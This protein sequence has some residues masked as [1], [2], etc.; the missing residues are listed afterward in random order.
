MYVSCAVS[1]FH[2]YTFVLHAC[3]CIFKNMCVVLFR[4][5]NIFKLKLICKISLLINDLFLS[6]IGVLSE[7]RTVC[8][9]PWKWTY[10]CEL[11]CRCWDL[12]LG[13]LKEQRVLLT[14]ELSPAPPS[15]LFLQVFSRNKLILIYKTY[16]A[17]CIFMFK[18]L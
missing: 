9:I 16:S 7:C 13:P 12:K 18:S 1:H 4:K 10:N 5:T 8:Q 2:V 3:F 15:L 17:S 11:L 14:T 6:C